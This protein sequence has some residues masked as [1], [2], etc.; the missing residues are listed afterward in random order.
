V[1]HTN[2]RPN[3]DA[4]LQPTV[5]EGRYH[6]LD[7]VMADPCSTTRDVIDF[8]GNAEDALKRANSDKES[9]RKL[10]QKCEVRP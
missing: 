4:F 1:G 8:G 9:A 6:S 2:L 7:E 3:A 10:L 5:I